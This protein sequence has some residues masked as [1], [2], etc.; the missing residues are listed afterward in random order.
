[1]TSRPVTAG[2][3]TNSRLRG[4]HLKTQREFIPTPQPAPGNHVARLTW[5]LPAY[6]GVRLGDLLVQTLVA[7]DGELQL[8]HLGG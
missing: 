4:F 7:V 2:A 8:L 5:P 6:L 3:E 1:M